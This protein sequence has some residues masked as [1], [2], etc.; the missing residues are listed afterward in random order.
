MDQIE[1]IEEFKKTPDLAGFNVTI[2]YKS[3][4]IPFL[5]ELDV[6]AEH[7][8]AVN[9]VVPVQKQNQLKFI[10][11]NTDKPA[12]ISTL[13]P[14]LSKIKG[15]LVLGSGGAAKAIQS[16]L[17]ELNISYITISR[18]GESNYQSIDSGKLRMYN[19][20]INCTPLGMY[21]DMST[22]PDL[23][24]HLIDSTN[25]LYDLVYNPVESIFLK[26]GKMRNC[27]CLNGL[28]M[29]EKQADLSF[30]LW[31]RNQVN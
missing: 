19:L 27:I 11:F 24:Y 17:D 1:Q 16:G 15:A 8:G 26:K 9:T 10:G 31:K 13:K 25:I 30:D 6:D 28:K 5:D 29:L 2:P 14:Y 3:S 18:K 20:I 4:I 12:F 22:F 23:P 21:P 7:I